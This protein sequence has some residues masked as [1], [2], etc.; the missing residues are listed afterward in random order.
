[1][2]SFLTHWKLEKTFFG[3]AEK[4]KCTL[5]GAQL[6]THKQQKPEALI[7]RGLNKEQCS[8][9]AKKRGRGGG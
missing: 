5:T 6:N 7:E 1:M 2:A 4:G 3:T 8:G 9:G